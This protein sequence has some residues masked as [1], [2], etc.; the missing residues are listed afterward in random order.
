MTDIVPLDNP[1]LGTD[2]PL[3]PALIAINRLIS[4]TDSL[5]HHVSS[6]GVKLRTSVSV[7]S[8]PKSP[9]ISTARASVSLPTSPER[10]SNMDTGKK[11]TCHAC[12][13]PLSIHS[14]VPHG[15]DRCTLPHWEGC[16]GGYRDGKAANGSEGKGCPSELDTSVHSVGSHSNE[17]QGDY[18]LK[19]D[20][21]L[22]DDAF[23]ENTVEDVETTEG[24]NK[25]GGEGSSD[26]D[27]KVLKELQDRNELLRE[28]L[29][30]HEAQRKEYEKQEKL[31]LI[32]QMEAENQ[33]LVERMNGD[34]G[35]AKARQ[36]IIPSTGS[37]GR[38]GKTALNMDP[39]RGSQPVSTSAQWHHSY[40]QHLTKN[41]VVASQGG[42]P[43][44]Q[45]YTGLD[46]RGIRKIPHLKEQVEGLVEQVQQKVP[47]LDRR[48]TAGGAPS[49]SNPYLPGPKPVFV[50]QAGNLDS[51]YIEPEDSF[52]YLRRSDGTIYKVP[53]MD[54][55]SVPNYSP[56]THEDAMVARNPLHE[57][58]LA[59][60]DDDCPT[61]PKKGWKYV[62]R[63]DN[64]GQKYF[65]EEPITVRNKTYSWVKDKAGR[66]YKK[67]MAEDEN[68]GLE[69]RTVIDPNT[70]M[71][72]KMLVPVTPTRP[73]AGSNL[74]KHR[75]GSGRDQ[76]VAFP[77]DG[78]YDLPTPEERQGKE[79][80]VP[81]IVQYARNCPVAWTSRVT[82]DKLNM[83]LWCWAY[84][85]ELL[86][87][88]TKAST[89]LQNGELEARLQ[90]FLNVLEISLQPSNPSEYDGQAWRIARLYAEKIQNK[91][92]RG[93]SWVALQNRYGADTHPH[94]L[95]A[96]QIELAH[97]NVK[98]KDP[99]PKDPK[100]GKDGRERPTCTTWNISQVENK[101]RYEVDNEGK[102]CN[103][104]HECSW[105]KEKHKKSL[106]HQR[107]FCRQ[108][109]SAGEQ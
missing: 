97:K 51:Q 21:I 101:C 41:Q 64:Y 48:P 3:S 14:Q 74:V 95:M 70:G 94:E 60:S 23:N 58:P 102:E 24:S 12:H 35:G 16:P 17:S 56:R 91:V 8:S 2:W 50:Q 62:W 63:R 107:S 78:V 86:A 32:R 80:K 11:G 49:K 105:C 68:Q 39:G 47:S 87:L 34:T 106:P 76:R 7:P 59:S 27:T 54:E 5:S 13:A 40:Q 26:D 55:N 92:D 73:R 36:R 93:G 38:V 19:K 42:R 57:D 89:A 6:L 25:N 53:V 4:S 69:L 109:I 66:T 28:Q 99:N 33:R 61:V 65:T 98:P 30:R 37:G 22:Q 9:L 82:S 83:G 44:P 72:T 1:D 88:Q 77:S 10:F 18:E 108:R 29:A 20:E 90:H 43:D 52:I 75:V 45:V 96:A 104:K 84:V 79:G 67:P 100:K 46:I 71:E 31:K 103:R 85:A 81:N 15:L